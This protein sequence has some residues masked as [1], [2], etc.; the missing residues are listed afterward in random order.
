MGKTKR[1]TCKERERERKIVCL[2]EGEAVGVA[3]ESLVGR[4]DGLL[5][6]SQVSVMAESEGVCR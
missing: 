4:S 3:V 6:A 2:R 1:R 5:A